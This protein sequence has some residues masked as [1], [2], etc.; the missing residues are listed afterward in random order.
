MDNPLT[1]RRNAL[2]KMI[3]ERIMAWQYTRCGEKN[4]SGFLI[5]GMIDSIP[6][7]IEKNYYKIPA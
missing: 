7:R 6:L 3:R 5:F 4:E 2:R 1:K